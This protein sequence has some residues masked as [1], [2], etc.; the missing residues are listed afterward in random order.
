M[1]F[2]LQFVNVVYH[3][4][5]FVDMKNPC[6]HGMN[7]SSSFCAILLRYCWMQYASVFFKIFALIF[8]SEIDLYFPFFVESFSGFGTRVMVA[9]RNEFGSSPSSA[10]F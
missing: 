2:I 8:F 5:G 6:I 1:A 7:P 4:D 9:S 3:T 10:I